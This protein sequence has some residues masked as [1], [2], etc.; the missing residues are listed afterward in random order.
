[1]NSNSIAMFQPSSFCKQYIQIPKKLKYCIDF[2]FVRERE[3]EGPYVQRAPL[4]YKNF[5]LLFQ[6]NPVL[7]N[8][9]LLVLSIIHHLCLFFMHGMQ[10][11][12]SH[13]Q[14][15]HS[16]HQ[17]IGTVFMESCHQSLHQNASQT[18]IPRYL[19]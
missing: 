2:E 3:R 8:C 9:M 7:C 12:S 19:Y 10:W 4:S 1:M 17:K 15:L 11:D 6:V 18:E 16:V 14:R 5:L 13:T